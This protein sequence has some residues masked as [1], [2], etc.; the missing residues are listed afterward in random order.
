[1]EYFRKGSDSD[2]QGTVAPIS[3]WKSLTLTVVD[4]LALSSWTETKGRFIL[5]LGPDGLPAQF[6]I[7]PAHNPALDWHSGPSNVKC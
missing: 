3:P 2:T 7:N 1:M 4:L 5:A 6:A